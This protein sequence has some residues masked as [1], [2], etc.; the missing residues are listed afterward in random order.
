ME[1]LKEDSKIEFIGLVQAQLDSYKQTSEL[2][3]KLIQDLRARLEETETGK[4]KNDKENSEVIACLKET[5]AKLV[6]ELGEAK[7]KS[8][9]LEAR[10]K[11]LE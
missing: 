8:E 5:N 3:V 10:L 2:N 7:L 9:F 4:K 6:T 11:A 1:K